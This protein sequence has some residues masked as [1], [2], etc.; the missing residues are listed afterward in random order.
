MGLFKS[1]EEKD[2]KAE[3]RAIF[4]GASLQPLGKIQQGWVV[5]LTLDPDERKLHIKNKK[6]GA[7]ITIP[8]D[9]LRGF[10]LEDETTLAKSGGTIGRA[11]VGGVLFGAAGAIVGGMS[12]KGKTSTKWYGTLSYEDKSGAAQEL[13]FEEFMSSKNA[14]PLSVQFKTLVNAIAASNSEEVT[15]L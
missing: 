8:Y 15:E 11:L 12:G 7:D 4:T 9:R 13:Y 2:V 5:D 6:A 1:K 3:R 14:S 10:T